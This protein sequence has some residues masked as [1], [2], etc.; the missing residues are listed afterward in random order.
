MGHHGPAAERTHGCDPQAEPPFD[1]GCRARVVHGGRGGLA[2]EDRPDGG[3]GGAGGHH[4]HR[5]LAHG[6]VVHRWPAVRQGGPA[7]GGGRQPGF[8]HGED[9]SGPLQQRGRAL[10]RVQG[11]GRGRQG[12]APQALRGVPARRPEDGRFARLGLQAGREQV[13]SAR[14]AAK[15]A[16]EGWSVATKITASGAA[17]TITV[18]P[19]TQGA[20]GKLQTRITPAKRLPK[21]WARAAAS[22]ST[23]ATFD[24]GVPAPSSSSARLSTPP[25]RSGWEGMKRQR[26]HG[27]R[28]PAHTAAVH[29]RGS[30]SSSSRAR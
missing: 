9:A 22:V 23:L 11:Q 26:R 12:P 2:L 24:S 28:P 1:A 15:N 18:T 19:S 25:R 21:S 3:F 29:E 5:P 10:D 8:V 14:A 7:D 27:I 20:S 4:P 13:P 16:S 17:A 6:Q 30:S